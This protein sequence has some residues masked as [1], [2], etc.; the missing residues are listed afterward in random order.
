MCIIGDGRKRVLSELLSCLDIDSQTV[1]TYEK[2]KA[3]MTFSQALQSLIAPP[4]KWIERDS[5][6]IPSKDFLVALVKLKAHE[7]ISRIVCAINIDHPLSLEAINMLIIPLEVLIRKNLGS[8]DDLRLK[9]SGGENDKLTKNSLRSELAN[10]ES[11]PSGDRNFS[12]SSAAAQETSQNP[13]VNVSGVSSISIALASGIIVAINS[14][15][16]FM[17]NILINRQP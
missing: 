17:F 15:R 11:V 6:I 14:C 8:T 4:T 7:A 12:I 16:I 1:D 2:L 3:V 5:F 9:P 13:T 10:Q